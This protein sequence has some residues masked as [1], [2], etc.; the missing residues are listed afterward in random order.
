MRTKV[1]FV[2]MSGIESSDIRFHSFETITGIAELLKRGHSKESV[3][4]GISGS[5]CGSAGGKW[6]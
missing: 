6:S 4:F 5:F 3:G 2:K 1:F